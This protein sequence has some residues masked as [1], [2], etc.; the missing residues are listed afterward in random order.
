MANNLRKI[1][2][3][4]GMT[5]ELAAK[6]MGTGLSQ[7]VKLERGERR[8]TDK[9]IERAA[10]AF[11]V[12]EAV[13]IAEQTSCPLVGYVG[14][15]ARVVRFEEDGDQEIGEAPRPENASED[16]VAV[17]VRGDSMAGIFDEGSYI[18]FDDKRSP[19]SEDL[20][21]KLCVVWVEDGRVLVKRLFRGSRPQLW[22]LAA[23]TGLIEKDVRVQFAARVIWVHFP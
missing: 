4:K 19:P 10:K 7:Y 16:T 17:E 12:S 20:I 8:L 14:A 23:A 9:W 3:D 22:D 21:G 11:H 2:I 6:L 18:Y 5:Q 13:V 1:R 15:G